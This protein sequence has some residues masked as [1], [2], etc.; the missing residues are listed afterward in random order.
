M[1]EIYF[2]L[3]QQNIIDNVRNDYALWHELGKPAKWGTKH[4]SEE[5]FDWTG[6]RELYLYTQKI[7]MSKKYTKAI[8]QF[9]FVAKVNLQGF[10]FFN[11]TTGGGGN[12][13][14]IDNVNERWWDIEGQHCDGKVI[15]DNKPAEKT[16]RLT[17]IK[18]VTE[19]TDSF[20]FF[21]SK[22]IA[23]LSSF[24]TELK[25]STFFDFLKPL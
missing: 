8:G 10:C 25:S 24:N 1:I 5:T 13:N 2:I 22:K 17:D 18:Q 21:L 9:P 7:L 23:K 19:A 3:R 15:V 20:Y 16:V 14:N 4:F 12:L 11:G 6:H